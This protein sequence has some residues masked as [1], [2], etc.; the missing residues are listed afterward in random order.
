M[1]L[2]HKS[3]I[4][5]LPRQQL[6]GQHRE[7]CA[8][9]G[10]GWG[11]KHSTVNYVFDHPRSWLVRFHLGVIQEM[12]RRGYRVEPLWL[13][14]TYRGRRLGH[15]ALDAELSEARDYPEHCQGY[16]SECL[17]NLKGKGIILQQDNQWTN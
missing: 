3:L 14:P 5:H 1:R 6:L 11:R 7:C 9:R 4:H 12:E 10:D 17:E 15:Q 8:L 16:L 2:W 13:D